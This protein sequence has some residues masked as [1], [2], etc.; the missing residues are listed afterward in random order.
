MDKVPSHEGNLRGDLENLAMRDPNMVDR[1]VG[2]SRKSIPLH[3]PPS[4]YTVNGRYLVLPKNLNQEF[5]LCNAV[6]DSL[7]GYGAW[8]NPMEGYTLPQD[9]DLMLIEFRDEWVMTH[10]AK[11]LKREGPRVL[12]DAA[13][14]TERERSQLAPSTGR[15]DY[16]IKVN[17][18]VRVKTGSDP[19]DDDESSPKLARLVDLSR[20]GM[21]LLVPPEQSYQVGEPVTVRVVGWD[22]AVCIDTLVSRVGEADDE[23][24]CKL[25]LVFP[26]EMELLQRESVTTFIMQVQRREA[27]GRALPSDLEFEA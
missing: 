4:A 13:S 3:V 25:A 22:H 10:H 24:K 14:T 21:A 11:V 17:L 5:H 23:G 6:I 2:D 9:E 15:H 1:R 7:D 8:V 26:S 16:R 18:P 12:V 27:L 20:G 19:S